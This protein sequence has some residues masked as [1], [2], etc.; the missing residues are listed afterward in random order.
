[1][2]TKIL[3]D[4]LTQ[5]IVDIINFFPRLVNGLIILVIGLLIARVARWLLRTILRRIKFDP[6]VER[7]GITGSLRGLQIKTPLSEVIAQVTFV[8]LLLSFLITATR[9]M[10]LEPVARLLEQLIA[11][12]PN[13]IAAV[14]IF[15]LGGIVANF[16]GNLVTTM[17]TSAGLRFAGRL[18]RTIQ[19]IISVFIV[20]LALNQLGI[21][22]ALLVTTVTILIAAFG[23]AVSLAFGLGARGVVQHILAG[24]YLRRRF[25]TGQQIVFAG[26]AGELGGVGVVNILVSGANG[27]TV[28]PNQTLLEALVETPR[29]PSPP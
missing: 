6:L 24:Y 14:I 27:D 1:M 9:L 22:T 18:G 25:V 8:L 5:I 21:N 29:P 15:L 2:N 11:F 7:T 26:V 28:V 23:L 12:L 13:T 16:V 3:I 17:G 4:A 19:Y 20:I 10:G